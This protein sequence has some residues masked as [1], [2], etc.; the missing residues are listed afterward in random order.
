MRG[1][2]FN[3]LKFNS[4]VLYG[5]LKKSLLKIKNTKKNTSNYS[6]NY[7]KNFFF[8]IIDSLKQL[9]PEKDNIYTNLTSKFLANP[10]FLKLAYSQIKNKKE[11]LTFKDNKYQINLNNISQN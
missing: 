2:L 3:V 7:M 8:N 5:K 10:E 9:Y 4:P 6:Y 11:N 1:N